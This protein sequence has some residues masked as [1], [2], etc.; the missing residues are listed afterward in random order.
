MLANFLRALVTLML[1]IVW[2]LD[3]RAGDREAAHIIEPQKN[4]SC[5]RPNIG[6]WISFVAVDKA[7]DWM[8]CYC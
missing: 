3:T 6:K 5:A 2:W 4:E 1:E 8:V 7:D